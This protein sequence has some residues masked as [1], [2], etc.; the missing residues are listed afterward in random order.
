[1]TLQ[2]LY[3][4]FRAMPHGLLLLV[5]VQIASRVLSFHA[6][7]VAASCFAML[8][9]S[10]GLCHPIGSWPMHSASLLST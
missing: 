4:V 8:F 5:A 7:A 2:L 3:F 9:L 1:M 6:L 10:A